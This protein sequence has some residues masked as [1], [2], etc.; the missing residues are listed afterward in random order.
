MASIVFSIFFIHD[1][2]VLCKYQTAAGEYQEIHVPFAKDNFRQD[3]GFVV[4]LFR[5]SIIEV[6]FDNQAPVDQR[7]DNALDNS[8]HRINHYPVDKC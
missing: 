5:D 2:N 4:I 3:D 8:I 7:V 6:R 1:V